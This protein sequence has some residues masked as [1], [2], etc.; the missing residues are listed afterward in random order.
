MVPWWITLPVLCAVAVGLVW[1]WLRLGRAGVPRE[2]RWLRRASILCALL[3]ITPLARGL[4]FVH[5]HED[6]VGFAL[7]WSMVLL[8]LLP[9]LILAGI[10][11][12]LTMRRGL[13]EL[14][15]LRRETL[16]GK[17]EKKGVDG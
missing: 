10:D 16:G 8:L 11:V 5:P 14:R 2:R 1:Y 4:T 12:C 7:A 17:A 9:C 3:A 6:R 15:S 13:D